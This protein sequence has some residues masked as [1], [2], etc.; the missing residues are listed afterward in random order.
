MSPP[1][2]PMTSDQRVHRGARG[3][4][5][6]APRRLRAALSRPGGHAGRRAGEPG[7]GAR[8]ADRGLVWLTVLPAV[9]LISWLVTGLPL[10]LAGVFAPVP[11]L[12]ITA[13]LAT[14]LAAYLLYRDPVWWPSGRRDA[15]GQ[16]RW[17]PWAALAGTAL[18]AAGYLA[19]ELATNSP[20]FLAT[21]PPGVFVQT[22]FW[23]AQHG[24]LPIPGGYGV[25]G[26]SHLAVHLSSVGF[27]A[28]GD[29][30]VPGVLPGLPMLLAAGFWAGGL[31]GGAV[32]S[33]VLAALAVLSFG[34]LVGRLV[35]RG[36]APAGALALAVTLPEIYTGRSAISETAVQILLFGG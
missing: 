29:S 7:R 18:V 11:T 32:V 35:G 19:W 34:G 26:G 14:A 17:I 6:A 10:L 23:I 5:L 15:A 1:E 24:R 36:W 31:S 3:P 12:L 30:V 2:S 9:L 28:R 21:R 4:L 27:F 25:L 8:L 22:G 16:D 33:P 20:A 13:P